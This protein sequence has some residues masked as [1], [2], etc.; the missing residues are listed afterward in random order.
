M[1]AV[2]LVN[3]L[4]IVFALSSWEIYF[5]ILFPSLGLNSFF[6]YLLVLIIQLKK[7]LLKIIL[8]RTTHFMG[9]QPSTKLLVQ[10]EWID[11]VHV[12]AQK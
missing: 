5:V 11:S 7:L 2:F 10:G 4:I 1:R 8:V 6:F 12:L 9:N 3:I